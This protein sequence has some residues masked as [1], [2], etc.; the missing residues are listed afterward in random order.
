MSIRLIKHLIVITIMLKSAV[1]EIQHADI[2]IQNKNERV[3]HK[4]RKEKKYYDDKNPF[5]DVTK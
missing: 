2:E 4:E 1:A 5:D 3:A